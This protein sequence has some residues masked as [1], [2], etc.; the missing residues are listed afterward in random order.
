[1]EKVTRRS[2][3][4]SAGLLFFCG[5]QLQADDTADDERK[6]KLKK[7][8]YLLNPPKKEHYADFEF[9]L[10]ETKFVYVH[11]STKLLNESRLTEIV[12]ESLFERIG[13]DDDNI[14][15]LAPRRFLISGA[16]RLKKIA[17]NSS[18]QMYPT[19]THQN[20]DYIPIGTISLEPKSREF[21]PALI[22]YG[23]DK[24]L[25]LIEFNKELNIIRFRLID[26]SHYVS[27][28]EAVRDLL[29]E[30]KAEW[31]EPDFSFKIRKFQSKSRK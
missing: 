28:F 4:Q 11:P 30:G 14:L 3:L 8:E 17:E 10:D 21:V 15:Y 2:L 1:M 9:Q 26:I 27:V 13:K 31:C 22:K 7:L 6:R 19:W 29:K 25:K 20:D 12:P 5:V 23:E 24:K 18:L 16:D